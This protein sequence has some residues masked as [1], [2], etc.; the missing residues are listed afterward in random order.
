MKPLLAFLVTM[1]LA[2]APPL[3]PAT[4]PVDGGTVEGNVI[5]ASQSTPL[6]GIPVFLRKQGTEN[7]QEAQR[8]GVA[9]SD[10][11][12]HFVLKDVPAGTYSVVADRRG[13]FRES[14]AEIR[15]T[16][17]ARATVKSPDIRMIVAGTISGRILDMN[18]L[19]LAGV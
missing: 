5:W 18:N 19:G 2:Q 4:N 3:P 6:E 13:Y 15:V 14:D 7:V 8:R 11:S 1:L 12:G 16:V 9:T 10:T 17:T